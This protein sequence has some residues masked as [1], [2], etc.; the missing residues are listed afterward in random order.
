MWS[1]TRVLRPR[2]KL[3]VKMEAELLQRGRQNESNV[4]GH[5]V[6]FATKLSETTEWAVGSSTQ[7]GFTHVPRAWPCP[8]MP[9]KRI[10][11]S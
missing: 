2:A 6:F 4:V 8:K 3:S 5:A 9:R 10:H 1:F 7:A 11:G